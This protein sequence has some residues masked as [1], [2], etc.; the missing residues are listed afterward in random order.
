MKIGN[1]GLWTDFMT[2]IFIIAAVTIIY[3][4]LQQT[5][6]FEIKDY[7]VEHG[8][9]TTNANYIDIAWSFLPVPI[10]IGFLFMII[11]FIPSEKIY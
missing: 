11:K 10:M 9:D 6:E 5:Y 7:G 8:V 4:I 3:I 2:G 1:R